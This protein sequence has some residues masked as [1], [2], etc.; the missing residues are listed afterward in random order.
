MPF[1]VVQRLV[2][3][4]QYRQQVTGRAG[5]RSRGVQHE[6][7]HRLVELLPVMGDVA[8]G[9][10]VNG[11]YQRIRRFDASPFQYLLVEVLQQV[12]VVAD[13]VA[14]RRVGVL[15]VQRRPQGLVHHIYHVEST[16]VA[17]QVHVQLLVPANLLAAVL[18]QQL[19]AVFQCTAGQQQAALFLV[20]VDV[21]FHRHDVEGPLRLGDA[22]QKSQQH[23]R[24]QQ[25]PF[26]GRS[27][28]LAFLPFPPLEARAFSTQRSW[29]SSTNVS[30][31]PSSV[32]SSGSTS[33]STSMM[34]RL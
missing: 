24:Y 12:L 11:Q 29:H 8:Y 15:H 7:A 18:V 4:L 17:V 21:G 33:F 5:R 25:V 34:L 3:S 6:V 22:G 26:H 27:P 31:R 13:T 9:F 16:G 23:D 10:L 20:V 2:D 19:V 30:L 28:F 1:D 32:S 14:H